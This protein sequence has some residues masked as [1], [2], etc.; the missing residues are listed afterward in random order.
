MGLRHSRIALFRAAAASEA[1][2]ACSM[3]GVLFLCKSQQLRDSNE[4]GAQVEIVRIKSSC[5][6]QW[7]MLFLQAVDMV[8]V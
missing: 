6:S 2:S 5:L 8:T 1:L 3:T 4:L 7:Q